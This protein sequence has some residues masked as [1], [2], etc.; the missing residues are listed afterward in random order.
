MTWN[1]DS[2][3]IRIGAA[4]LIILLLGGTLA[5]RATDAEPAA[6]PA[7]P[8]AELT[9]R[10]DRGLSEEQL[11]PI[12]ERIASVEAEVAQKETDG[13]RDIGLVLSLGNLYYQIGELDTA[14]TWYRNILKTNPADAPALENLGQD[15]LEMGDYVGTEAAWRAA[16]DIEAYEPVYVKLADL[17]DERFPERTADIQGILETAIANLGQTPGLL[18]RLGRWYAEQG[19]LDEAI[20]HYEVARQLAPKDTTIVQEL[21]RLKRERS[22]QAE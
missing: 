8:S 18:T 16:L 12:R 1:I 7:E 14:A 10:V 20:S 21:A 2:R 6:S 22:R 15:L 9:P 11:Q 17:I 13:S 3:R 5:W 4:L 19:M